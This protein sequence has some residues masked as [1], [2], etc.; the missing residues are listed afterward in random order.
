MISD[1]AAQ[2]DKSGVISEE[3]FKAF[4]MAVTALESSNECNNC[5]WYAEFEGICTNGDSPHA[6]D[7]I[8][9][10]EENCKYFEWPTPTQQNAN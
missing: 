1:F 7:F 6:G 4:Q 5:K 8:I 10:P 2:G 3:L 9:D